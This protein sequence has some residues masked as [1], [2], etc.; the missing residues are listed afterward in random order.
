MDAYDL[1]A[2][3]LGVRGGVSQEDRM[4][5]D[6]LNTLNKAL[7]YS[8]QREIVEKDGK[9]FPLLMNNNK[10]KMDYDDKVISCP[11]ENG[12]EV[13][14]IFYWTRIGEYWLVYLRQ[15][16]EDAYFRGFARKAQHTLR[17][18]N[19]YGKI[20]ETRAAVR[21]PVETKIVDE[22]KSNISFDKPNYTLSILV[23]YN[24]DTKVLKR[25]KKVAINEEVWEVTV[26]D[27]ISEKGV[28]G[29]ELI[30][31][32]INKE[33]DKDIISSPTN[34]IQGVEVRCSLDEIKELEVEEPFKLWAFAEKNGNKIELLQDEIIFSIISG[35]AILTDN[36]LHVVQPPG[37]IELKLEIPKV[38]FNKVFTIETKALSLPAASKYLISGN[39]SVKSYGK[40]KY[41]LEHYLDGFL[42]ADSETYAGEWKYISEGSFFSIVSQTNN[43]IVFQ[44]TVGSHGKIDLEYWIDNSV[45]AKKTITVKSLI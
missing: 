28:I 18:E 13:G 10:L 23:P 1:M 35:N 4:V 33:E 2:K 40:S 32:Y 22:V 5:A 45:V 20:V 27:S 36:Y 19:E 12:L 25:Y 37:L 3:R 26:A 24:E 34:S 39:E 9:K 21:G 17:W 7:K 14:S 30:E 15:Y 43:E 38:G 8:Y 42:N 31:S 29:L 41:Q 16:S 44:W 6:K 11:F